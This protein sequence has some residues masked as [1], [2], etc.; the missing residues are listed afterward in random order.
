MGKSS[1]AS[2]MKIRTSIVLVLV[3]YLVMLIAG[4]ALGVFSLRAGNGSLESI[5]FNQRGGAA[6]AEAVNVYRDVRDALDRAE[7]AR[8]S[9]TA[10]EANARL[11]EGRRHF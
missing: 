10:A 7:S 3:F 11:D 4:A 6:L 8:L 9:G 2:N 1:L 5:V